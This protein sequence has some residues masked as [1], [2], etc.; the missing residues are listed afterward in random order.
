MYPVTEYVGAGSLRS[1]HQW[2]GLVSRVT[3]LLDLHMVILSLCLPVA[4]I[5]ACLCLPFLLIGAL[6]VLD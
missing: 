4:F 3:F 1:K 5:Y 2:E 6:I